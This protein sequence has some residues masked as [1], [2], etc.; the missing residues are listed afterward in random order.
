M[1]ADSWHMH[2]RLHSKAGATSVA[3]QKLA[4]RPQ[5]EL[6]AIPTGVSSSRESG[7][8]DRLCPTRYALV[9]NRFVPRF[10]PAHIGGDNWSADAAIRLNGPNW[11]GLLVRLSRIDKLGHMR[12]PRMRETGRAGW[13]TWA[14][15]LDTVASNM[16]RTD[17]DG[18]AVKSP[19]P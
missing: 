18:E 1:P 17:L 4:G 13:W 9:G 15:I 14:T 11:H 16:P 10:D 2:R 8:P 12:G 6:A 19:K 7:S 5:Q 3:V